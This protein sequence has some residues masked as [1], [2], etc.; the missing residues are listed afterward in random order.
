MIPIYLDTEDTS[1]CRSANCESAK[2]YRV[3]RSTLSVLADESGGQVYFAKKLKDLEGVYESVLSDLSTIYSLGYEP[4][5]V[6]KDGTWS[7]LRV[8][9]RG[10]PDL[11]AHTRPGYY[12]KKVRYQ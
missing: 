11:T 3:A 4:S 7:A 2:A 12:S 8:E 1:R 9:I 10:H 6:V 5:D